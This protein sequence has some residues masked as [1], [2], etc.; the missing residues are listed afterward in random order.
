M[1]E[2]GPSIRVIE[3]TERH[4]NA[5]LQAERQR[6]TVLLGQVRAEVQSLG[7]DYERFNKLFMGRILHCP[8]EGLLRALAWYRQANF[9]NVH[10]WLPYIC[11][12]ETTGYSELDRQKIFAAASMSYGWIKG[13]HCAE[14]TPEVR[15]RHYANVHL[16]RFVSMADGN[17][18][19][20]DDI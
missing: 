16:Y 14:A 17:Q 3:A 20:F 10:H 11:D 15:A 7:V 6:A 2:E 18:P 13:R 5:A 9:Q 4:S 12:R 19:M 1:E 8:A